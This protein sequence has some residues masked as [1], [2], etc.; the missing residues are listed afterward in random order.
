MA[1]HTANYRL[2]LVGTDWIRGMV[3][4]YIILSLKH[5]TVEQPQFW[6]ADNRGYTPFLVNCGVYSLSEIERQPMYYNDGISAVAIPLTATALNLI[7]FSVQVDFNNLDPFLN[8]AW[9]G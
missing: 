4:Q 6:M 1:E 2:P 3:G 7:G 9:P 5:S 8:R